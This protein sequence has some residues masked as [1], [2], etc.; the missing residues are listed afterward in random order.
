MTARRFRRRKRWLRHWRAGRIG[1]RCH[2]EQPRA[3][4]PRW[5]GCQV[6]T[7]GPHRVQDVEQAFENAHVSGGSGGPGI[8]WKAIQNHRDL[9]R[10]DLRP[11]QNCQA[12]DLVRQR[13]DPFRAGAMARIVSASADGAPQ[14]RAQPLQPSAPWRP[15]KTVGFVA[16]SISGRA[17]SMVVSTGPSPPDRRQGRSASGSRATG[18]R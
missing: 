16:P 15:A 17:I 7:L 13:L 12:Q 10:G 14:W 1:R 5:R 18:C 11:A 2:A 9:A 8:G 4:L 3:G 6:V